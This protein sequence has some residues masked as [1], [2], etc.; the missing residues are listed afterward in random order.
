LKSHESGTAELHLKLTVCGERITPQRT[1]VSR[2]VDLRQFRPSPTVACPQERVPVQ[3]QK[4]K[5]NTE[6]KTRYRVSPRAR[7]VLR[8]SETRQGPSDTGNSTWEITR[9]RTKRI[10]S[11]LTDKLLMKPNVRSAAARLF[12]FIFFSFSRK[13]QCENW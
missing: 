2:S 8:L 12:Y 5:N 10:R 13:R 11:Q 4:R 3:R 1:R 7:N 9:R 6:W